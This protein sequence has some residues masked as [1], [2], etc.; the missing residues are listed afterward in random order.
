MK[1]NNF[2]EKDVLELCEAIENEILY[3]FD[4][5]EN[6]Q[7]SANIVNNM[8]KRL[9]FQKLS[10]QKKEI[11]EMIERNIFIGPIS[12]EQIRINELLRILTDKIKNI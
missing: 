8:L 3:R 10:Q 11:I 7:I 6:A 9:I 4:D 1:N 12:N 5:L 2:I